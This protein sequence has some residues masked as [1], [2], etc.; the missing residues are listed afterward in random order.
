MAPRPLLA[1]LLATACQAPPASSTGFA[2]TPEATSLASSDDT[3]T[4]TT[5]PPVADTSTSEHSTTTTTAETTAAET[6][7]QTFDLGT[8]ADLGSAHPAGCKGKIDFLFMISREGA[9]DNMQPQLIGAFPK[10]IADLQSQ[11]A[12]FDY[13]IMVVDGDDTWGHQPCNEDCEQEMCQKIGYPCDQ[14]DQVTWCDHLMGTGTVFPAGKYTANKPCPIAGGK[15][16]LTRAEPDLPGAFACIAQIGGSGS[17]KL[18]EA[19]TAAFTHQI[20]GP[21]G[22]NDDFLRDDA[23]LVVT[24]LDGLDKEGSTTGSAGTP[25][26]WTQALVEAKH[27]DLASVVVLSIGLG[28]ASCE[29]WDRLC[30]FTKGFPHHHLANILATDYAPAFTATTDLVKDACAG[31][32]PPPN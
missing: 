10:F 4:G 7:T 32:V 31:F 14:L 8:T 22:C 19:L 5:A 1:L 13:H 24:L 6:L 29:W 21:G 11:F 23:L 20:A 27:G 16:F 17:G 2:S 15:R 26:Q 28:D 25:T 3:S 30:T 9:N 18:G 12:D